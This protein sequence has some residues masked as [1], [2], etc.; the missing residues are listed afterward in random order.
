MYKERDSYNV[1]TSRLILSIIFFI[2]GISGFVEFETYG[3]FTMENTVLESVTKTPHFYILKALELAVGISLL[4]NLF[5]PTSLLIAVP[6]LLSASTFHIWNDSLLGI[7]SLL[8][9]IPAVNLIF[10]YRDTFNLFFKP[11]L[12]TNHMAEETPQILTYNE[13]REKRPDL[14]GKF[15]EVYAKVAASS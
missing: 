14:T 6:I 12:Y 1:I 2:S 11:Q 9:L 4:A 5:V 13:V 15:E 8:T 10:F 3:L 7:W